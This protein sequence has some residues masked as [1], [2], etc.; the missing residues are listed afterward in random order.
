M[1]HNL[2]MYDVLYMKRVLNK[3]LIWA[4]ASSHQPQ[5]SICWRYAGKVPHPNTSHSISYTHSLWTY[6]AHWINSERTYLCI[7]CSINYKS[8]INMLQFILVPQRSANIMFSVLLLVYHNIIISVLPLP[9]T[10]PHN[11]LQSSERVRTTARPRT[12]QSRA[13]HGL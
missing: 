9:V 1:K 8:L 3:Q 12:H 7:V 11:S 10:I 2:N 5:R 4:A 6:E 13:M